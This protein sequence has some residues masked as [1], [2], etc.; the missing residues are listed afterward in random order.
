MKFACRVSLAYFS[1]SIWIGLSFM[2]LYI[3]QKEASALLWQTQSLSKMWP[4]TRQT[5]R[6]ISKF[7]YNMMCLL[8]GLNFLA[9]QYTFWIIASLTPWCCEVSS[10]AWKPTLKSGQKL[11]NIQFNPAERALAGARSMCMG[12]NSRRFNNLR[13]RSLLHRSHS[14][15]CLRVVLWA[16]K[17]T[18]AWRRE[19]E[20]AASCQHTS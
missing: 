15:A 4:I 8:S 17:N 5:V 14:R 3:K 18:R 2:L 16:P 6:L 20:L 11:A 19:A 12:Q 10:K 7:H 13:H 1:R 9:D